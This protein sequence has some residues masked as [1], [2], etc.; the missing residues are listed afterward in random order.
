MAM[1]LLLTGI[2]LSIAS[3]FCCGNL[4]AVHFSVNGKD[5]GCG[6]NDEAAFPIAGQIIKKQCCTNDLTTLSVDSNYSPS[7]SKS[8]DI[9]PKVIHINGT[10]QTEIV[11][12]LIFA[13]NPNTIL[14]PPG[15]F[16]TY[17]VELADICVFRI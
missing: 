1:I 16:L 13:K 2:H 10:S 3:H 8:V 6:M 14:S 4:V 17:T 7:F 15:I 12:Q 9:A 5:A 11:R